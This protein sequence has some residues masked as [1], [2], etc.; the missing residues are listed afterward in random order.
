MPSTLP[1]VASV[2]AGLIVVALGSQTC[3]AER[4]LGI[5]VSAKEVG[6]YDKVEFDLR[7]GTRY[8]NAFDPEEVDL[9]ILLEAPGGKRL[10]IPAFYLQ[11]YQR[12]DV[13]QGRRDRV[14][15]YP[16]GQPAWKARFAPTE[17]GTYEAIAVLKDAD[18]SVRSEP[19]RFECTPS[20]RKGF[21]RVS[22]S[23]PRFFEFSNGE[24]FFAIGQNLAFIGQGQY[25]DLAKAER[26]FAKLSDSG[27]NYLRIWTC[28]KDWA[29][30]VEA[31]KS[32]WGRS[33]HWRPPIVPVPEGDDTD[34]TRKCVQMP[35]GD[36]STLKPE[37]SHSVA[38][39]P[40]TQYVFSCRVKTATDAAV[41]CTVS[42]TSLKA[43]VSSAADGGWVPLELTF[44]T[45]PAEFWLGAVTFRKQGNGKA[46]LEGLSL[47]QAAGGP[48][49]LWEA[50]V[51]RPTRGYYNPIDSFMLD[52]VVEAAQRHGIYLQLCLITRDLYMEALKD[53][54]SAEYQQAIRDA[55]RLLRYAVAR[56]GYSTSVAAWEHFN[57]NDPNLPT[58]RFYTETGHY[59]EQ[60]DVYGHL[61]STSTW[62]PSPKDCRHG[63]LDLADVHFY[64]RPVE[65]KR[66]KDEVEAVVDRARYL[67][68]HAP[69]K[70]ALIG[71]FG[72]ANDK[73]MP[74]DEM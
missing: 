3:V 30:A 44:E 20:E 8:R 40:E 61:R 5:D 28:C 13:A 48:E 58:D 73:W 10:R 4:K 43:P 11:S 27:A 35:E 14:W 41:H 52:Q 60:I 45:G 63:E 26:I 70:P 23:D 39:R 21:L 47:K 7:V 6:R 68:R 46:W 17:P 49:L 18:G 55:K 22:R 38:L 54:Q 29:M 9:N 66:L 12:R 25:V 69:A 62:H 72:L 36:G 19:V 31:R 50:D 34:S 74:T 71:E 53:D 32:A 16:A 15:M 42:G 1:T 64:L 59:L 51:N 65:R 57:E 24:P 67:R 33:W 37:P 56:W 2:W